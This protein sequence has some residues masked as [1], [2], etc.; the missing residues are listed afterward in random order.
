M[1]HTTN[2]S[3]IKTRIKGYGRISASLSNQP[4]FRGF[5]G[6]KKHPAEDLDDSKVPEW[7]RVYL[8]EIDRKLDQLLG[9]QS[10]KD[11]SQDF[12][13]DI[14]VLEISGNGIT[15]RTDSKLKPKCVME[16]VLVLDKFP[17]R[18]VS[19]KGIAEAGQN[20]DTWSMKFK[21]IKE[22]DLEAIIKFVFSEQ[23]ERIRTDKIS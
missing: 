9:V 13:I 8:I 11:I 10:V 3:S 1:D 19:T 15:F 17:L 7:L 20:A 22:H 16:V 2:Y 14:E 23:R 4:L 5:G 21:N 12:P 18:M 6:G